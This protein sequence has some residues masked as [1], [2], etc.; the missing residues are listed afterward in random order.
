M[1]PGMRLS[2]EAFAKLLAGSGKDAAEILKLGGA[3]EALPNF[4]IP[5]RLRVRLKLSEQG[6]QLAEC[7]GGEAGVGC[8]SWRGRMW[9]WRRT[10]MAMAMGRRC[11]GDNLYNGA[12][13]DAAYV[14]LLIQMADDLKAGADRGEGGLQCRLAVV[15]STRGLRWR[16][17]SGR[18]CFARLRGRRKGCWGRAGLC[19]I[20]R[21]RWRSW[22]RILN[23]DQLRPLF[24]LKILTA[25]AVNETTLGATA[26]GGGRRAWALRFARTASRSVGCC[27]GRI[28]IRF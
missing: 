2:A 10:W 23:L 20:R 17:R 11:M 21:C 8:D 3:K 7:A 16:R 22:R 5:G 14:A 9:W 6:F 24:P 18:F 1:L 26:R 4:E 12:L 13:D 27:G 25:E 28:S 15:S 19:S